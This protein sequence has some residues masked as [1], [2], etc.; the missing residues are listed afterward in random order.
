VALLERIA[1]KDS[2]P[3]PAIRRPVGLARH[4][5][6]LPVFRRSKPRPEGAALVY[7]ASKMNRNHHSR[8]TPLLLLSASLLLRALIPIG[9]M[10][11]AAGSGLVFEFCP[12]GIPKAFMQVLA[13]D[14]AAGHGHTGHSEAADEVHHCPVGHLLLSAAAVDDSGQAEAIPSQSVPAPVSPRS[15]TSVSRTT[16]HSR[17]PPA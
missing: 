14:S 10:P 15:W 13:G 9:Y 3:Q 4:R 5:D 17:G 12:E 11:A 2:M 16:Y 8:L 1:G 6:T 7:W